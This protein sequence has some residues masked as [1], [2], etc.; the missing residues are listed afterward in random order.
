MSKIHQ[1][2]SE[3]VSTLFNT[4]V[5][6]GY[7]IGCGACASVQDSPIT[8]KL[9]KYGRFCASLDPS[10]DSKASNLSVLAV[11]PFSGV[12]AN[13]DQIG[14]ELFS[15]NCQHHNRIGYYWANYAGFVSEKDF[16]QHGSS[17]GMG[18]WIINELFSQGLIDAV[19]H[20]HGQKPS[21]TD[22]KSNFV[23]I[24]LACHIAS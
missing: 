8:M 15:E 3:E 19:I 20:V 6:G 14:Q 22:P 2:E 18:T 7:C 16:R 9:D 24:W 10:N 12:S 5:T 17:G 11:C 13:E 21:E 4:V 1:N 23:K